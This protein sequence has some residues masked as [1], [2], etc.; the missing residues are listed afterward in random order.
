MNYRPTK[1]KSFHLLTTPTPPP[2][3]INNNNFNKN[4]K[5]IKIRET[6]NWKVRDAMI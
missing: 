6:I 3:E 2:K 4:N 1:V 5:R